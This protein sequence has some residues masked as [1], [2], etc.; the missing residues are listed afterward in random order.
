MIKVR[1]RI[2]HCQLKKT[3]FDPYSLLTSKSQRLSWNSLSDTNM[4]I[5]KQAAIDWFS[6]LRTYSDET[7][8]SIVIDGILG[9]KFH[10]ITFIL[11]L[12]LNDDFSSMSSLDIYKLLF[13]FVRDTPQVF[14]EMI[15]SDDFLL[16]RNVLALL[17]KKR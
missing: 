14:Q 6:Q 1:A 17:A 10:N 7:V 15:G 12:A 5:D 2:S 9:S 8:K 3:G 4:F 16:S 11:N 13:F